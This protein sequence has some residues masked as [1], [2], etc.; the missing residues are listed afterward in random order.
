M[1]G[2][3]IYKNTVLI[4]KFMPAHK[5]HINMIKYAASLTEKLTILVDNIPKNIEKVNLLQRVEILKKELINEKNIQVKGID[6]VTYQEPSDSKN[7]WNFWKATILRNSNNEI[8]SIIGSEL[9][10]KELAKILNIKYTIY[11]N[12]R[13]Q[14]NISAT[15]VR[16]LASEL[17]NINVIEK[18]ENFIKK[19]KLLKS[20]IPL[21]TMRLYQKN[22]SINGTESVGKTEFIKSLQKKINCNGIM[23]AATFEIDENTIFNKDFFYKVL[24]MHCAN[25][26]ANISND[27]INLIDNSIFVT[28]AYYEFFFNEELDISNYL[29]YEKLINHYFLFTLNKKINYKKDE[30]RL[31][32]S[33]NERLKLEELIKKQFHKYKIKYIEISDLENEAKTNTLL[34]NIKKG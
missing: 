6:T 33:I 4:G 17:E 5:G 9:Y 20:M 19:S 8:D 24:K 12:K 22:I 30:H 3:K 21:E 10:I 16:N 32:L 25:M 7:F 18:K 13:E 34:N 26:K 23:E 15:K 1:N 14:F 2:I 27:Y 28:A 11:D 31:N 29:K